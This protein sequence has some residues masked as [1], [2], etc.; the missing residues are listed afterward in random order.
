MTTR[1]GEPIEITVEQ[2]YGYGEWRLAPVLSLYQQLFGKEEPMSTRRGEPIETER[3][4]VEDILRPLAEATIFPP[5]CT[6]NFEGGYRKG[7]CLLHS[8]SPRPVL[9]PRFEALRVIRDAK[10]YVAPPRWGIGDEI[11]VSLGALVRSLAAC[12]FYL[13]ELKH[14]DKYDGNN[15]M[16]VDG[17]KWSA[18]L[19]SY[20]DPYWYD[21]D[22]FEGGGFLVTEEGATPEEALAIGLVE[23]VVAERTGRQG[24]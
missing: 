19:T 5:P 23:A 10:D 14:P 2:V 11:D 16:G 3:M 15:C 17:S 22:C 1:R 8:G 20:D 24:G 13:K 4:S 7:P 6:C 18:A 12:G 21:S 9:D